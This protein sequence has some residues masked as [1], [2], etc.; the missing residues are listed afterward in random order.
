MLLI[1]SRFRVQ[2]EAAAVPRRPDGSERLHVSPP[3]G[4]RLVKGRER[5]RPQHRPFACIFNNH[6]YSDTFL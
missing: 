1:T 2:A 3:A 4:R 6:S 5:P